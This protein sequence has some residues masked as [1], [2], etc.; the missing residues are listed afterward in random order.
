MKKVLL[1]LDG[2]DIAPRFDLAMEVSIVSLEKDGKTA[3]RR[4]MVLARPSAEALC[5]MV[6]S[7][8]VHAVICGGIEKDY[9]QY[10]G[11]KNMTVIHSVLGPAEIALSRFRAGAL[12]PRDIL[13][14]NRKV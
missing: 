11:W 9:I 2:N 6:V 13:F 14:E 12:K 4:D 5:R 10:L 7:E 1:V 3:E 8:N